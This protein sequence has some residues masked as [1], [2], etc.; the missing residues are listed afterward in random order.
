RPER[1]PHHVEEVVLLRQVHAATRRRRPLELAHQ[2][3]HEEPDVRHRHPHAR[4]RPPPRP[5]R[6]HPHLLRPR[7]RAHSLRLA[8]GHEPLRPEL[9]RI[10]PRLAVP[11]DVPDHEVHTRAAA[12]HRHG[13]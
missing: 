12:R 4:A 10:L 8:A 7:H 9:L 13:R 2:R 5:E 6:H 1:R 3:R 11:P